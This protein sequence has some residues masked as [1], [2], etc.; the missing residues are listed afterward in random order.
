MS[1]KEQ[2]I[3]LFDNYLENEMSM[4][5]RIDFENRLDQDDDFAQ[6]FEEYRTFSKYL[7]E[8]LEQNLIADIA[9][10]QTKHFAFLRYKKIAWLSASVLCLIGIF[11]VL[12][13]SLTEHKNSSP[14][15]PIQELE[16]P[17]TTA[18]D[19]ANF[20]LIEK[21]SVFKDTIS[22]IHK[23]TE[24][25]VT[26]KKKDTEVFTSTLHTLTK[27]KET[28]V[29]YLHDT[30]VVESTEELVKIIPFTKDK[31][32]YLILNNSIYKKNGDSFDY[33]KDN[34]ISELLGK[35]TGRGK[36]QRIL[37]I[38]YHEDTTISS[39]NVTSES[40][41]IDNKKTSKS[42]YEET[43]S[44]NNKLYLRSTFFLNIDDLYNL[45]N[46]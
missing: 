17:K 6:D 36:K 26:N 39:S 38:Y 31:N 12:K 25:I 5:E 19:T 29:Y 8:S 33:H 20:L 24:A 18:I 27:C 40:F 42:S 44:Q 21:D 4:Q 37:V 30:I 16:V 35:A 10:A 7:K 15:L 43:Q 34:R 9:Q 32:L 23:N 46:N 2:Y 3:E 1:F 22:S 14:T 45:E 28:K 41:V 13:H 11:F